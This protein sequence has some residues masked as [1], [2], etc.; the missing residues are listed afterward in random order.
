MFECRLNHAVA[1][2]TS[3]CAHT[4]PTTTVTLDRREDQGGHYFLTLEQANG[5]SVDFSLATEEAHHINERLGWAAAKRRLL[6]L[7]AAYLRRFWEQR[8]RNAQSRRQA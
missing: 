7:L 2:L 3:G 4:D 8:E 1:A 6:S 5:I